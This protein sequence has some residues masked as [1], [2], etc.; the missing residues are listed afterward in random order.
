MSYS[1]TFAETDVRNW[2]SQV[3]AFKT[4][5]ERSPT[6]S[7]DLVIP[8]AGTAGIPL[9]IEKVVSLDTDPPAPSMKTID[10]TLT[11]VY[12][13]TLLALH[14]FRLPSTRP[15]GP[16]RKHLLFTGSL[17]SYLDLP[18]MADYSTAKYGVRGLFRTIRR[19]GLLRNEVYLLRC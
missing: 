7:L 17:A 14:Y 1:A 19:V 12:F 10:V 16:S 2:Q 5:I 6:R 8:C 11:G 13:S 18:P 3:N 9:P 15:Q 4:A